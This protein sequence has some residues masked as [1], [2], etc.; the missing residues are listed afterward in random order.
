MQIWIHLTDLNVRQQAAAICMALRGGAQ[1]MIRQISPQELQHGGRIGGVPLD[2]VSYILTVLAIRF[3]QL[4]DESRLQSMT[5]LWAF[6]KQPGEDINSLLARYD[7]VRE[8][9]YREGNFALTWE[10]AS[11]QLIRACG[12]GANQLISLT[13]P[14]GGRLPTNEQE[15]D[16]MKAQLRRT[17]HILEGAPGNLGSLLHGQF[18]QART[19][20]TYLTASDA[21]E[22]SQNPSVQHFLQN[23]DSAAHGFDN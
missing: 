13:Q 2:P 16:N 7:V 10:G 12:I 23:A 9:A 14:Y 1:Q 6:D 20:G 5:E 21:L 3:A 15:F 8:R 18:H 11:L 17:Y 19:R 22:N 4:D